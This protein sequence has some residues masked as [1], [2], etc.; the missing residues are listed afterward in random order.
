M[1]AGL[2]GDVVIGEVDVPQPP[3]FVQFRGMPIHTMLRLSTPLEV[4]WNEINVGSIHAEDYTTVVE[5]V[6][7]KGAPVGDEAWL[8]FTFSPLDPMP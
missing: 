3:P 2:G 4:L 8:R 7:S 5:W 1:V 6:D